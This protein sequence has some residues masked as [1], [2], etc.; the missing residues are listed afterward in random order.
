MQFDL[1]LAEAILRGYLEAAGSML[2]AMDLRFIPE[3][4]RLISFELGLRFFTD[5]LNGDRYFKVSE[6]GQ[7]LRRA[8]VQFAL[9]QSIEEQWEPLQALVHRLTS[10]VEAA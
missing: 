7:N 5:H 4:A 1:E 8:Q 9:T 6:A 10:S 2:T 3:S